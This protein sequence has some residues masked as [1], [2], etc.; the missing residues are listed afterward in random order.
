MRVDEVMSPRVETVS[1]D[2]PVKEVARLL[3]GHSIG[4]APVVD[5]DHRPV[6]I[7]TEADLLALEARP[8]PLRHARRDLPEEGAA[9]RT[10]DQVMTAPVVSVRADTDV[11]DVVR[12]MLSAQLT[13]VPVVDE[14][15]RLAGLV[16]RH[17]LVVPLARPDSDIASDVR[18]LL[19]EWGDASRAD[20]EV[21][22]GV[23]TLRLPD[24]LPRA[25]V[26]HLVLAIPGVLDLRH[27]DATD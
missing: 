24:G 13:R 27:A 8:D 4:C 19:A 2:T 16:S 23:V 15:G 6:G 18:G 12:L 20:V 5:D 22:D 1:P 3:A 25:Q 17:D 9:V 11:A 26:G 21:A 7:I 14:D 10:A